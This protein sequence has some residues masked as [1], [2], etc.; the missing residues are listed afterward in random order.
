MLGAF[1]AL[2]QVFSR[3]FPA[4]PVCPS[5]LRRYLLSFPPAGLV[6]CGEKLR[7]CSCHRIPPGLHHHPLPSPLLFCRRSVTSG[8]PNPERLPGAGG[9]LPSPQ[10]LFLALQGYNSSLFLLRPAPLL[11]HILHGRLAVTSSFLFS[12]PPAEPGPH[13][14]S[15]RRTGGGLQVPSCPPAPAPAGTHTARVQPGELCH[16]G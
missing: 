12:V 11:Y 14:L 4:V 6:Q 7:P 2:C 16:C 5:W 8:K 13:S 9:D 15:H 1:P 3:C 10:L